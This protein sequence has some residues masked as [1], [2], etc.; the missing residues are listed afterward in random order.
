LPFITGADVFMRASA[1]PD[2]TISFKL[3]SRGTGQIRTLNVPNWD[4]AADGFTIQWN[5]FE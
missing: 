5:D 2:G 3:N 4:S 1:P